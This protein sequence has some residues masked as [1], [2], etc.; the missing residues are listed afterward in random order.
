MSPVI[1][2]A[3]VTY[4][5]L[6]LLLPPP[7]FRDGRGTTCRKIHMPGKSNR[8]NTKEGAGVRTLPQVGGAKKVFTVLLGLVFARPSSPNV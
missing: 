3:R 2:Q 7:Q 8:K 6:L 1:S 4:L 5:L